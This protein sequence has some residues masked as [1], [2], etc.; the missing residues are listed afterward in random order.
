MAALAADINVS[1]VGMPVKA[2]FSANAVDIHYRGALI[3]IDTGGGAQAVPAAG[4]RFV[5]ISPMRQDITA[6]GQE[7]EA[8]IKGNFWFPL[9]D[10]VAA[11]DEGDLLVLDMGSVQSDNIA[12]CESAGN[13]TLAT[14][15]II[16]GQILRV[17]SAAMLVAIV[18]GI[19]GRIAAATATNAWL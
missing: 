18:P 2:S 15:D 6:I 8:Y 7:L 5:G 1:T 11:D 9:G 19:A 17:K 16:I 14:T 10:S 12:D 3:F 4:D 13:A